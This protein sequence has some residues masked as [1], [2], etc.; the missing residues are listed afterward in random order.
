MESQKLAAHSRLVTRAEREDR[1]SDPLLS[2]AAMPG[3]IP[4]GGFAEPAFGSGLQRPGMALMR[5]IR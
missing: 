3:A 4:R 1:M 5:L 2:A